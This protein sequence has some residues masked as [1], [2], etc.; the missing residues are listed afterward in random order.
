MPASFL[1]SFSKPSLLDQAL[2]GF[3]N[4]DGTP[5]SPVGIERLKVPK[6]SYSA[7]ASSPEW[8]ASMM[9]RVYLSGHREPVPYLPPVQPV[10]T[11]QQ[12]TWCLAMRSANISAYLPGY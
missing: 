12:S 8:M 1:T 10:L 3:N 6:F 11:S 5:S 9:R 2:L 4:S 7:L